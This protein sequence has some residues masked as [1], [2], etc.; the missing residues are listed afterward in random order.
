MDGHRN[1]KKWVEK[2]GI[3]I[4]TAQQT[5]VTPT[6]KTKEF[7]NYL[8][9]FLRKKKLIPSA[10]DTLYIP[11]DKALLSPNN[12]LSGYA[13]SILYGALYSQNSVRK[14]KELFSEL[15]DV[16]HQ[17]GGRTHFV[18][19]VFVRSPGQIR[20]MYGDNIDKFLD[21]K[22]SLDPEF[23]IRNELFDRIFGKVDNRDR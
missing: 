23:V 15:N 22:K 18:K 11:E 5:Y 16:C 20:K 10:I 8:S 9:I 17:F 3:H 12:G 7:L 1:F 14:I 21:L 13:T 6:A 2:F 19:N 4:K